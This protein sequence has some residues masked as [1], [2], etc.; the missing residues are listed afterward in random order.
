MKG[1]FLIY[2]RVAGAGAGIGILLSWYFLRAGNPVEP[3]LWFFGPT[4]VLG[5]A[6]ISMC[7]GI[8]GKSTASTLSDTFFF[9]SGTLVI[10]FYAI[11]AKFALGQ[12]QR[13]LIFLRSGRRQ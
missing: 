10:S 7:A 4:F 9:L 13:T 12:V 8:F 2:L 3:P 11:T 5:Y 1:R 6:C